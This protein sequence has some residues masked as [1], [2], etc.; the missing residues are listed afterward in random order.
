MAGYVSEH[1]EF[2]KRVF[3]KTMMVGRKCTFINESLQGAFII[4]KY[5]T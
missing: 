5:Q 2:N 1:N 4:E 3:I